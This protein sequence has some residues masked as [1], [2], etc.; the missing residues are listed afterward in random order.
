[1]TIQLDCFVVPH[2]ALLTGRVVM[3]N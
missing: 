1:V 3:T 2:D